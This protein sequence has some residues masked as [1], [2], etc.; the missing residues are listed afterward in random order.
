MSNWNKR[1]K[2]MHK[3]WIRTAP[4]ICYFDVSE[5]D[6]SIHPPQEVNGMCII[7]IPTKEPINEITVINSESELIA[8]FG[9]PETSEESEKRINMLTDSTITKYKGN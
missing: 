1:L 8:L 6:F 9:Q 7:G 4:F 3:E 2:R 5:T